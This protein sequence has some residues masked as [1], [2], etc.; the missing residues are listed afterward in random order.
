[1]RRCS[2]R[3]IPARVW[4]I[5]RGLARNVDAYKG[6]LAACDQH[7]PQRSRR[8]RQLERREPRGIHE[9]LPHHL[10]RPGHLHGRADAAR[11]AARAHPAVGRRGNPPRTSCRRNPAP[12]SKP[13]LYRG[14]LPRGDAAAIVGTGERQA[15]R[16]VSALTRTRRAHLRKHARAAAPRLPGYARLALDAGVVSGKN[17]IAT[18]GIQR[19]SLF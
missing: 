5:A 6:H 3:S 1:M 8:P 7:A 19:P 16:V 12:F 11:P 10:H 4:S 18:N 2:M 9:L 14:E 13:L 17:R 15:R